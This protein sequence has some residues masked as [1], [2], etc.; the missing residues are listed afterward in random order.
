VINPTLL[1]V[2]ALFFL[3]ASAALYVFALLSYKLFLRA[4]PRLPAGRARAFLSA[5]LV[6][7]SIMAGA[8]T[9]GGAF[10]R[11]RHALGQVHNSV[12]CGDIARFLAMPEGKLPGM[13]GLLVQGAAWLLLTY[14]VYAVCRLWRATAGLDQGLAPYLRPPS[15][16]LATTIS[17]IQS[18]RE[19]TRL[20]F[21]EA[22]IPMTY[23]CL[24]GIRR[25]R[26][27]LSKD[28]VASST[29]QELEAVVMHEIHHFQAGDVWRTLFVGTLNC[30]FCYLPPVGLLAQHWR[31]ETEF[32]CD[33]ATASAT[34]EPLALAAAILRTQG[35]PV[36]DSPL[37]NT[38][39][40][41]AEKTACP[42]ERRVERL[43]AYAQEASF[44]V[45]PAR[46]LAWQ[47]AITM[48]LAFV[49]A[50][51]LLSPQAMCLAH[52]SLEAISRALH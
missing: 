47:W 11:H 29:C 46:F 7:P 40:G 38:T 15:Q 12:Y 42:P 37:A 16:K 48:V 3:A 6:L 5:C 44:A 41:F 32:A 17:K 50:L 9:A 26:C 39:L 19:F 27:V 18:E 36:Q 21:F 49:G 31:E 8:F 25:V 43:L 33:A 30:L 14:G 4:V 13:I 10:L 1:F 22:D 24:I 28:L 23:S 20:Q 51:L 34:R 35:V 45:Q 2:S 52:C